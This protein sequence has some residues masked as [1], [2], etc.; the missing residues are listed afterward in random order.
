MEEIPLPQH[1]FLLFDDQDTFAREHEERL[2]PLS[3]W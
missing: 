3:A 2:R 1:P